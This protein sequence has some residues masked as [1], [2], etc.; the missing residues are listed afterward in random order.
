LLVESASDCINGAGGATTDEHL[1][2]LKYPHDIIDFSHSPSNSNFD[3]FHRLYQNGLSLREVSRKT[4]FPV[5]TIRNILVLNKVPLRTNAKATKSV[6]KKP[7][8]SF[9]GAIPYGK[10][11]LDG[12]LVIDPR[13]LKI[14]RKILA[15]YKKGIS[16]NAISKI[17][18]GQNIPSKLGKKWSDKTVASVINKNKIN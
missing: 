6:V 15:L 9:W 8:R 14:V 12:K 13:E 1:Y 11:V 16:F 3:E 2:L 7:L 17:L 10:S 5:S 4:D 18:N